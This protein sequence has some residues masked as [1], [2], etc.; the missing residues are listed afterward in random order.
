MSVSVFASFN[1]AKHVLMPWVDDHVWPHT[2]NG[3]LWWAPKCSLE[4]GAAV[5][6]GAN[7]ECLCHNYD[8]PTPPHC[9]AHAAR[10]R[11][12]TYART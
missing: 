1:R 10:T 3:V 11:T 4:G 6:R 9:N 5:P 8:H 2:C 7:G 12:R